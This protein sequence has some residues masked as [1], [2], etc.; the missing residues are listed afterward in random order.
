VTFELSGGTNLSLE[1]LNVCRVDLTKT[2]LKE[3]GHPQSIFMEGSK[4]LSE[5]DNAIED[6]FCFIPISKEEEGGTL[7]SSEHITREGE[8]GSFSCGE[9]PECKEFYEQSAKEKEGETLERSLGKPL[10]FSKTKPQKPSKTS[11]TQSS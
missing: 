5:S 3:G 2:S 7:E 9:T 10:K 6:E 8:N 11:R 1:E 4:F